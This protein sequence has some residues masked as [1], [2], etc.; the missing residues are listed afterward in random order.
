MFVLIVLAVKTV[1]KNKIVVESDTILLIKELGEN[2]K[3]STI[4]N[5]ETYEFESCLSMILNQTK[6]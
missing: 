3:I 5:V 1:V 2:L 4:N 6:N